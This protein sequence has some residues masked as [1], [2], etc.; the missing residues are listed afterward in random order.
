MHYFHLKGWIGVILRIF[1]GYFHHP[2]YY[3][4]LIL[5]INFPDLSITELSIVVFEECHKIN[6]IQIIKH[7]YRWLTKM[8]AGSLEMS[9]FSSTLCSNFLSQHFLLSHSW[10]SYSTFSHKWQDSCL[11]ILSLPSYSTVLNI[12]FWVL[13]ER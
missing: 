5:N 10:R 8:C 11:G 4:Y 1:P 3:Y 13:T 12:I 7:S 2:I 9:S 6:I